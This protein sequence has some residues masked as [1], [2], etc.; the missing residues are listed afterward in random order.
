MM[1]MGVGDRG[2]GNDDGEEGE[3]GYKLLCSNKRKKINNM[4]QE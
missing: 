4:G 1:V 2:F 3:G